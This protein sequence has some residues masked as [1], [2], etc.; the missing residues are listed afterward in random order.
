MMLPGTAGKRHGFIRMMQKGEKEI[1]PRVINLIE[2]ELGDM[3]VE[4]EF[5]S[6]DQLMSE[7][8]R[9]ITFTE[10]SLDALDYPDNF[11]DAINCLDVLEHTYDPEKIIAQF[12]RVLKRRSKVFITHPPLWRSGTEDTTRVSKGLCFPAM[13]HI[14]ISIGIFG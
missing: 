7:P 3:A 12:A 10:G 1:F 2:E 5:P 4:C 6:A 11:F 13:L 9:E 14:S 8:S